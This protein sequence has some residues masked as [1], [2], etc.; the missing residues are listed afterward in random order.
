M[1]PADSCVSV[2]FDNSD[3]LL[4]IH[5]RSKDR[6]EIAPHIVVCLTSNDGL[7][8]SAARWRYVVQRNNNNVTK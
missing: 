8:T 2:S 6:P 1:S 3:L 4:V 5:A 7:S